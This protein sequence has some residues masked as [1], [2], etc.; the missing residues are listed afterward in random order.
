M[1]K[2]HRKYILKIRK[3]YEVFPEKCDRCRE[4]FFHMNFFEP[5]IVTH[6]MDNLHLC[7]ACKK[8]I[9]IYDETELQL[10]K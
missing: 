6:S 5:E 8:S 10:A 2:M 3:E 7:D 1:Y 4:W 9:F